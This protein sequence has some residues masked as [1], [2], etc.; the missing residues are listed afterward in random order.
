[1]PDA[2]SL[3][4]VEG[5][6]HILPL[7]VYWEDTDASGIVYYANYLR[8]IERGRS[9][10]LRLAGFSQQ[11]LMDDHGLALTVRTCRI[12]YLRP[13]RLDDEIEVHSRL[14][15]LK[16]A[17]VTALQSV[18]RAGTELA[19]AE[20]RIACIDRAGRPRRLPEQVR[21]ALA[22]ISPSSPST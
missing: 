1:M 16:G 4:R 11:R 6:R 19:R 22:A 13:A 7:R 2:V 10:L 17:S 5:D 14:T 8:F 15:E 21:R 18:L 3:G 12:D 20:V 9:D